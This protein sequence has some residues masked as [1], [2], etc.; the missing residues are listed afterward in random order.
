MP[1]PI[2]PLRVDNRPCTVEKQAKLYEA[3]RWSAKNIQIVDRFESL[4]GVNVHALLFVQACV[5]GV[6]GHSENL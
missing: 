2:L 5:K 4:Y 6:T 1:Y 3:H